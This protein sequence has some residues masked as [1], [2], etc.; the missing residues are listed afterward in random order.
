MGDDAG[1]ASDDR[2]NA[3]Q[4]LIYVAWAGRDDVIPGRALKGRHCRPKTRPDWRDIQVPPDAVDPA[5]LGVRWVAGRI[6]L[7]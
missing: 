7:S 4:Q 3:A 1:P 6:A 5:A 2:L